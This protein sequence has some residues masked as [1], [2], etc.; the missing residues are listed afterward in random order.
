MPTSAVI[1][2]VLAGG[3][4]TAVTAITGT[5]SGVRSLCGPPVTWT[6][7]VTRATSNSACAYRKVRVGGRALMC[8]NQYDAIVATTVATR[9]NDVT[10]RSS[11]ATTAN[12]KTPA[13]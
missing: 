1:R 7:V 9:A 10:S 3:I 2:P 5:Y 12:F 6:T 4:S 13:R 11:G 8:V